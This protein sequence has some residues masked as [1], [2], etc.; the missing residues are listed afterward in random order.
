MPKKPVYEKPM[1]RDMFAYTAQGQTNDP[2]GQCVSGPQPYY[3]CVNGTAFVG[4]C[5]P[6]GATPDTSACG[7]GGFHTYPACKTGASASTTCISGAHQNF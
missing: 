3:T 5:N 6:T 1:I 2:H 7:T 4:A